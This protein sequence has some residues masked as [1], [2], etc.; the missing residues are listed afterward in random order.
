M[1]IKIKIFMGLM[2]MVLPAYADDWCHSP[3]G[4]VKPCVNIPSSWVECGTFQGEPVWCSRS[5]SAKGSS[6]NKDVANT[7]IAVAGG[8]A[9]VGLMWYIFRTPKSSNYASQVQLMEF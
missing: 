2:L 1:S 8:V 4:G 9:F 3:D 7:V 5:G 6:K